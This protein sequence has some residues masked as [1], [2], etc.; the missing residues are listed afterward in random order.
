MS[1]SNNS[2]SHRSRSGSGGRSNIRTTRDL[3]PST[4]SGGTS[5]IG[6]NGN[7]RH[8]NH[9]S[10]TSS[11]SGGGNSNNYRRQQM[12][13]EE[14]ATDDGGGYRVST[15]SVQTSVNPQNG[16]VSQMYSS[17][18]HTNNKNPP[19]R[20]GSNNSFS[21]SSQQ[22]QS[23]TTSSL[24][25]SGGIPTTT[26][27]TTSTTT[28]SPGIGMGACNV[29]ANGGGHF[30]NYTPFLQRDFMTNISNERNKG[31]LNH[32]RPQDIFEQAQEYRRRLQEQQSPNGGS[33]NTA[34]GGYSGRGAYIH[35]E[36]DD[37][38]EYEDDD[39]EEIAEDEYDETELMKQYQQG[40]DDEEEALQ[41][42]IRESLLLSS[43]QPTSSSSPSSSQQQQ[44]STSSPRSTKSNSNSPIYRNNQQQ[45]QQ[46]SSPSS[47]N[48]SP[49]HGNT[50]NN[51][52]KKA[53]RTPSP[54]Y[55]QKVRFGGGSGGNHDDEI[56]ESYDQYYGDGENESPDE[57]DQYFEDNP[58]AQNFLS[59]H[60]K[61]RLG[62]QRMIKESRRILQEQQREY[63]EALIRDK[64]REEKLRKEEREKEEKK[65]M[66]EALALSI[67]M[68]KDNALNTKK[69]RLPQDPSLS[70]SPDQIKA[71]PIKICEISISL[72]PDGQRITR[73]F[74][75]NNTLQSIRDWIDI[76]LHENESNINT[77]TYEL[78]TNFPKEVLNDNSK[79]IWDLN[80]YPKTLLNLR[81]P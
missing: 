40:F 20:A 56:K 31:P 51:Q 15:Q 14:A 71:S 37:D 58:D 76:Y 6:I 41:R 42:A 29:N 23:T 9:H 3:S 35:E 49:A 69:Q 52:K 8:R 55:K 47:N 75:V 12:V 78:V 43:P 81:E 64:E 60:E 68:E 46:S 50:N 1:S 10:S 38:N 67:Q 63:Q 13:V 24:G 80:L 53:P 17:T 11:S 33:F 22:Q 70:L 27:A 5:F 18:I 30:G 39:Y 48:S 19:T 34:N 36:D 26:T 74:Y 62:N 73:K 4:S 59:P 54:V 2:S 57:D 45:Q 61:Q 72:P 21:Y 66:E 7:N 77:D 65:Q 32:I 44:H 28:T 79:T 25:G 16:S